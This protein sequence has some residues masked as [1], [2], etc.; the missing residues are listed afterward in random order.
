MRRTPIES[1]EPR[2]LLAAVTTTVVDGLLMIE[3]T[4][5]GDGIRIAVNGKHP[6]RLSILA[7]K[8]LTVVKTD[9]LRGIDINAGDGDDHVAID[10]GMG[11]I[12]LARTV[13]LCDGD[14]K[15]DAGVGAD[16]VLG[17]DGSDTIITGKGDDVLDGGDGF[18]LLSGGDHAD[19]LYGGDDA[20]QLVGG[21]GRDYLVGGAGSDHLDAGAQADTLYGGTGRDTL[22]GMGGHDL[23]VD[24]FSHDSQDEG[25]LTASWDE[26]AR[27]VLDA[28]GDPIEPDFTTF[29]D[30]HYPLG[31]IGNKLP[32]DL[33]KAFPVYEPPDD[34]YSGAN[35]G[36]VSV[37]TG[38]IIGPGPYDETPPSRDPVSFADPAPIDNILSG[39]SGNDLLYGG[40]R[41]R[42]TGGSGRDVFGTNGAE[43]AW[44]R[45]AQSHEVTRPMT[46]DPSSP[47]ALDHVDIEDY[48]GKLPPPPRPD[49][50]VP[51]GDATPEEYLAVLEAYL[52]QQTLPQYAPVGPA[53]LAYADDP[54]LAIYGIDIFEVYD[55]YYVD[56]DESGGW[57]KLKTTLEERAPELYIPES[58]YP[59]VDPIAPALD[60]YYELPV[61][62]D[63]YAYFGN[64]RFNYY[65]TDAGPED[66]VPADEPADLGAARGKK[67]AD[68][69]I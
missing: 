6:D 17:G 52:Q 36:F 54:Q 15:F 56:L 31:S 9:G 69:S 53:I 58:F 28:D 37:N 13:R 24:G 64:T 22:Q 8:R 48:V 33:R 42:M 34:F 45:N 65:L 32:R 29:D 49:Y 14:D 55:P 41:D 27:Q 39:G 40:E 59:E 23:L 18:D 19:V 25:K 50:V 2:R 44:V 21:R 57:P 43:L 26:D 47:S 51:A 62:N 38:F 12:R 20:D 66:R 3:G 46:A 1:L 16:S 60:A 7:N 5:G 10:G 35:I 61:A 4:R 30:D 11:V 67:S 63:S 68:V